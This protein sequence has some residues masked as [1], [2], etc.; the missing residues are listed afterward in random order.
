MKNILIKSIAILSAAFIAAGCIEE[1]F[2]T[3]STVTSEQLESSPNAL[4]YLVNGIPS[5]E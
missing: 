3:G 4:Q 2:P 5:K 1:T